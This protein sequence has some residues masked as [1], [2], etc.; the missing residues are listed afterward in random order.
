MKPGNRILRGD[1]EGVAVENWHLPEVSDDDGGDCP[2][3]PLTAS[4]L[5]EI[6]K[7]AY[8]EG[9]EQGRRE[10]VEAG[11]REL[12][13]RVREFEALMQ[14]LARPLERLDEAVEQELVTLALTVARHLVR[15][16]LKTDPGEVL[17]VVREAVSQL[18]VAEGRI[19][20]HLHPEDAALVRETL[21]VNEQ[22]QGWQIIEDPLMTRGGCRVQ[23]QRSQIDA[24]V[25]NRLNAVIARVMGGERGSDEA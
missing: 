17:G 12:T 20:V 4:Q 19:Q 9:F 23:S 2:G 13:A 8:A 6:Q 11:Q 15:R 22:E 16:E 24:T 5:E 25:E 14:T 3:G 10:G 18:P 7:A 21:S 1:D